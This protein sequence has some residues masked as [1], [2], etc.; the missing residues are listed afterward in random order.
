MKK[1]AVLDAKRNLVGVYGNIAEAALE[2]G[3]NRSSVIYKINKMF[4][5]GLLFVHYD[6]LPDFLNMP[7]EKFESYQPSCKSRGVELYDA[8]GNVIQTFPSCTLCADFLGIS[9]GRLYY[10]MSRH[11]AVNGLYPRPKDSAVRKPIPVKRQSYTHRTKPTDSILHYEKQRGIFCITP[12]PFKDWD[13]GNRPFVG[14]GK[15][16][17]CSSFRGK[18]EENQT[19]R[20]SFN[21]K[22]TVI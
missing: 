3:C 6:L 15:C 22:K 21:Y 10:R 20:C 12:C 8:E 19:V 2:T 9:V 11:S 13:D 17:M 14:S 4:H 5:R 16:A 18:D 1:I 7:M